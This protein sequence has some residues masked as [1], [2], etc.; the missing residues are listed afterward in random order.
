MTS[1]HMAVCAVWT[2]I[3][4][5]QPLMAGIIGVLGSL[6]GVTFSLWWNARQA[7][8]RRRKER[9]HER[10]TLR[11]ALV[12]ELKI[13]R[14]SFIKSIESLSTQGPT[15][16]KY[17]VPTDEM[18]DVY[19]SFIDRIGLLSQDEVRKVMNA[20]LTLRSYTAA[21]LLHFYSKPLEKDVRHVTVPVRD[22]PKLVEMQKSLIGPLDEAINALNRAR[23]TDNPRAKQ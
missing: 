10:Q 5:H 9:F 18:E 2:W 11:V 3:D 15:T 23:D 12:E 13:N 21:V 20:Y 1:W 17:F 6:I 4:E 16:S 22:S 19:R 7:G 8:I 14:E